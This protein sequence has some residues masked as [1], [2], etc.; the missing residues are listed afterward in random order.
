[1]KEKEF[2][3][4]YPKDW[5]EVPIYYGIDEKGNVIIDEESIEDEFNEKL[6]DILEQTKLDRDE[7]KEIVVEKLNKIKKGG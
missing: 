2:I 5:I 3:R 1:M 6:G 7:L 4:K